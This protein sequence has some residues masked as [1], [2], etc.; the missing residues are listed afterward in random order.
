MEGLVE[1]F[2]AIFGS[3]GLGE[4]VV[5]ALGIA[6]LYTYFTNMTTWT[7][8][9]NRSA[10][11]AAAEGELPKVLGREH[12]TRR[13]P[14]GALVATGVISTVVLLLSALFINKQD[15]LFFAI[16]A[17]SSVIF[18]LPYLL[19][20]PAV[21]VLRYKDPDRPRPFRIPGGNWVVVAM[22]AITSVTIAAGVVLFLW[23]EIPDA[24]AEWSYTGPLL[25][26]VVVTLLAGEVMLWRMGHP[27]APRLQSA[28]AQKPTL[29]SASGQPL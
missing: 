2:R 14:V 25:G 24:P 20:Y 15:S 12:P 19:M 6:A 29:P 23:P 11:E 26:I 9:A 8:G 1:T 4:V 3:K 17:A 13:T 28:P 10:V 16:F 18:L 22:A 7:M 5:Y 27:R 21:A